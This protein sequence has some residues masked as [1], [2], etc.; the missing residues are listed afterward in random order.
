MTRE[1]VLEICR[2]A[3]TLSEVEKAFEAR[4][5]WLRDH[6]DDMGVFHRG[7]MLA[8]MEDG[9]KALAQETL[10]EAVTK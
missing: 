9:L 2:T 4:G 8:M 1:E 5:R 6:P 7:E 3:K 10:Q